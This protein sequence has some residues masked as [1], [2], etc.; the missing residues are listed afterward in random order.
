MKRLLLSSLLLSGC[1]LSFSHAKAMTNDH[2]SERVMANISEAD[3]VQIALDLAD[4]GYAI[5][6]R[7]DGSS[8]LTTLPGVVLIPQNFEERP[9]DSRVRVLRHELV[10]AKQW[11]ALG[12][13]VFGVE[14]ADLGGRF[15]LEA[16]GYRQQIRDLYTDGKSFDYMNRVIEKFATSFPG[17]YKY[18]EKHHQ[19][20]EDAMRKAL[21]AEL[22]FCEQDD[23][24]T[25]ARK[26]ATQ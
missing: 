8:R 15:E 20:I 25:K 2:M 1:T 7:V 10:H 16:Q 23:V 22:V 5:V 3:L 19:T 9:L 24:F 21:Q 26:E 12:E 4:I 11:E 13:L 18:P 6:E 17:N 14:Y